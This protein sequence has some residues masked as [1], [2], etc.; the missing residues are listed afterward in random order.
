MTGGAMSSHRLVST[1]TLCSVL[2]DLD[3]VGFLVGIPYE[4]LLGHRGLTHSLP[5]ALVLASCAMPLAKWLDAK[6]GWAF[7]FVFLSTISHGLL[8]ALTDDGL[9]VAFFS[10]FSNQRFFFPW[11]PIPASPIGLFEIFSSSE[12]HVLTAELVLVWLPC[13]LVAATAMTARRL[14]R[15]RQSGAA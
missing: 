4:S 6:R 1:A 8:D 13:L 2:P 12:S 5:F 9:G 7:A 11:R 14:S 10:P 3:S 15:G